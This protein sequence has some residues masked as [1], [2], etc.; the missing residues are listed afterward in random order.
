MPTFECS[1]L[2]LADRAALFELTQDY[3]R[4][5]AWDPFLR[6]AQLLGGA[7][8]PKV[9]VRAWCA[10]WYGLGMET[11]YVTFSPPAVTA[12]RMTRGPAL[13]AAFAGSWRFE[14]AG[15]GVTRVDFRYHLRARPR[16][17]R[18]LLEPLLAAVFRRDTRLRLRALQQTA[19]EPA[20]RQGRHS[21]G[22]DQPPTDQAQRAQVE[23][24]SRAERNAAIFPQGRDVENQRID[25]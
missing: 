17:L 24:V 20:Q 14:E 4:R 5:L 22:D 13:L 11:E 15:P 1:I 6:V 25:H 9:G 2:I 7:T 16:F 8:R 10:A 12:V 23:E 19:E 18:P 21:H 3:D